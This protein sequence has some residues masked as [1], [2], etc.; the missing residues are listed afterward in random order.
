MRLGYFTMPIHPL[1][2]DYCETLREDRAAV[3]L[4]D[5]LGFHDA[6]IGEH[7][8]DQAENITNSLIFLATLIN[9][10]RSIK[11][12][13]GV[14]NLSLN[15]PVLVATHA[16]MF[17]HLAAGGFILGIGPGAL[18]SDFEALGLLGEDRTKMF[19]EAIDVILAIWERD[20]PYD[21]DFPNNRYKVTTRQTK[22]STPGV[23]IMPKPFQKPRP[24]IV[25]TC[26][27][28]FSKNIA[29]MGERDFH[30][31]SANYLLPRWL[32][33]HWKSYAAG[34]AKAGLTVDPADW[35]VART[36][37]VADD[38]K[39]AADYARFDSRR[40]YRFYYS[41]LQTKLT[42]AK[43]MRLLSSVWSSRTKRLPTIGSWTGW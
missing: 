24:E 31:L 4:A 15:H 36:I 16:A 14:T 9:E 27:S 43:R 21:I 12:G 23:G 41:Q 20:A 3:I 7:L 11:L 40:P 22:D 25:G 32:P 1:E 29:V 8:T 38:D 34:K 39:V 26:V 2:R 5:R 19:A 10:T 17:D 18:V 30:P 42:H 6:F 33:Y 13:S 35:R 37:F 28:P